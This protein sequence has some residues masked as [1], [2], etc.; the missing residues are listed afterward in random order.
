MEHQNNRTLEGVFLAPAVV[1]IL[2]GLVMFTVSQVGMVGSLRDNKTLLHMVRVGRDGAVGRR[3][4]KGG[5]RKEILLHMV[6]EGSG[7]RYGEGDE[8]GRKGGRG[9]VWRQKHMVRVKGWGWR[10]R[11]EGEDMV[12][13]SRDRDIARRRTP[14]P[15]QRGGGRKGWRR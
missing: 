10:G 3:E 5:R 7:W 1:L 2:L 12:E 6:R 8:S 15:S 14:S 11:G 13:K 9:K 4:I